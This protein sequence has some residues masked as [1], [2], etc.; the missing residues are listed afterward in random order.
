[1][2]RVTLSRP[3]GNALRGIVVVICLSF[4]V[5]TIA[6]NWTQLKTYPWQFRVLPL[7]A[8]ILIQIGAAFLWATVWRQMAVRSGSPIG[9][10]QGVG[11]HLLSNLAKYIPGSIW[12]YVSRGYLGREHGLTAMSVGVSA[13]WEIGIAI[14]ASLLLVL[15]VMPTYQ[16]ILPRQTF[17]VI[18]A[19]ATVSLLLLM[20][21]VFSRWMGWLRRRMPKAEPLDF[22]WRD[23]GFYLL[24][25]L[26]THVLVGTAFFLFVVSFVQVEA[27]YWWSFVVGWSFAATAGLVAV[28]APY[29]LGVKEGLL[30]L[31]L[32][33]FMPPGTAAL[34][35][36]A[37]RLWVV[38]VE[39]L[40]A[41]MAL[42]LLR[43]KHRE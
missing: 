15:T 27:Q 17:V 30:A 28:F 18:L 23:L 7:T 31:F 26:T 29:G 34:L 2:P 11:V 36:L 22:R 9:W 43:K 21:P 3:M 35:A 20:P 40:L 39:I 5:R 24:A 1:M 13:V 8:S 6:L 38:G 41:G 14:V 37:S 33:P 42:L 16:R 12:S 32:Q 25:A 4:L 19:G 10:K